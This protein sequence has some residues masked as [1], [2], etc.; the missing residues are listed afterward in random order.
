MEL[1]QADAA[2]LREVFVESFVDTQSTY[3]QKRIQTVFSF[4]D[5]ICYT[6]YLWDCLANRKIVSHNFLLNFLQDRTNAIYALWDIHSK[7]RILQDNYWQ[8][9]KHTVISFFPHEVI[10]VIS[11]LPDDCYFFDNTLS[12][13]A[14]ITH[15]EIKNGRRLC[16]LVDKT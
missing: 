7:E 6:G 12:W 16:F 10:N 11:T 14:A 9:P 1:L 8:Y 4:D 15:E 2:F 3:Y 5:G 13:A